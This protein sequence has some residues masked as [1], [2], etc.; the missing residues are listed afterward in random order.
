[1]DKD[2]KQ[3]VNNLGMRVHIIGGQYRI[4]S[5]T[6]VRYVDDLKDVIAVA[7]DMKIRDQI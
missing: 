7:N 3:A 5:R 6:D 1:M 2:I 4:E